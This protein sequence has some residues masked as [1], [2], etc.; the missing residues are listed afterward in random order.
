MHRHHPSN[1]HHPSLGELVSVVSLVNSANTCIQLRV[2]GLTFFFFFFFFAW[3]ENVALQIQLL[4]ALLNSQVGSGFIVPGLSLAGF[5]LCG[6]L[7]AL[8]K[9]GPLWS[10]L[11]LGFEKE[12]ITH[13][14]KIELFLMCFK[15]ILCA[16][17][18]YFCHRVAC[19]ILVPG[20]EMEPAP[21][22][23]ES[24]TP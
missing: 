9:L 11:H 16:Y 23:V 12:L 17:Y 24:H 8:V 6:L 3:K 15:I 20:A 7:G 22:A 19:R 2:Y 5:G 10:L 14:L 13:F 18:Y 4:P 21:I 1:C